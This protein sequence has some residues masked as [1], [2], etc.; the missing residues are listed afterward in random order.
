ME[1]VIYRVGKKILE[2]HSI[3]KLFQQNFTISQILPKSCVRATSTM[4]NSNLT[5]IC[6]SERSQK[7]Y[8]QSKIQYSIKKII[9]TKFYNFPDSAE[10]LCKGQIDHG[11]LES[12]INL[13]IRAKPKK[14][15]AKQDTILDK[16]N[17]FNK[18]L[19]FPRFC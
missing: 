15:G 9:S 1:L 18:I 17:Y 14:L 10:K 7:H 8:E 16:I 6:G 12:D 4:G 19:Q 2:H 11:E 5:L 3:K 13:W